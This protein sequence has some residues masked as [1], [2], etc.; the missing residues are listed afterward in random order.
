MP[1]IPPGFALAIVTVLAPK[2][3]SRWDLLR[4]EWG[5]LTTPDER[6]LWAMLGAA[7]LLA[8]WGAWAGWRQRG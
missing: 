1:P 3:P 8:V 2:Q 5:W 4:K 7:A 6:V